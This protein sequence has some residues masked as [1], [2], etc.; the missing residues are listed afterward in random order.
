MPALKFKP[1]DYVQLVSPSG[2]CRYGY[3]SKVSEGGWHLEVCMHEEGESKIG[4]DA[5]RGESPLALTHALSPCEKKVVSFLAGNYG[6]S[7]IA[8]ALCISPVTVRAHI[9]TLRL[10]FHLDNRQQLAAYCQGLDKVLHKEGI[11][12]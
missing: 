3:V 8:T 10:K 4:Y 2:Y 12:V 11:P 5:A 7:K 6:T 9:R 1:D